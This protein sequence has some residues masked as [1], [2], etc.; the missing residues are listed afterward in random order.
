MLIGI[1]A[2]KIKQQTSNDNFSKK[3]DEEQVNE[4][5]YPLWMIPSKINPW[6]NKKLNKIPDNPF[7]NNDFI[8]IYYYS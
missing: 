6:I 1:K 5:C 3:N 7:Q 2:N 4:M 8:A